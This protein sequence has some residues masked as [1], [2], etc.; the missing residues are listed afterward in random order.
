MEDEHIT[1]KYFNTAT[2]EEVIEYAKTLDQFVPTEVRLNGFAN[3]ISAGMFY[4]VALVDAFSN[5]ALFAAVRTPHITIRKSSKPISNAT[6]DPIHFGQ[7][8]ELIDR[9]WLGMKIKGKM[10]WLPVE[11]RQLAGI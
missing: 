2:L 4:D 8:V 10:E 9:L 7:R 1:L 3:W 11:T 5:P 6:F